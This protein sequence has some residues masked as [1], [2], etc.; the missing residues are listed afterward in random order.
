MVKIIFYSIRVPN[1]QFEGGTEAQAVPPP[2][3]SRGVI[4]RGYRRLRIDK[5][6]HLARPSDDIKAIPMPERRDR[7]PSPDE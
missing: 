1:C 4:V 3:A 5:S 7:Q 6:L 2:N